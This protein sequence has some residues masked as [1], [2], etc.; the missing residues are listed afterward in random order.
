MRA[1]APRRTSA[2]RSTAIPAAHRPSTRTSA[3]ACCP[4]DPALSSAAMSARDPIQHLPTHDVENVPLALEDYDMFASD[5]G[6]REAAIREGG[7]WLADRCAPLGARL[8]SAEV[9]A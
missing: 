8:G 4:L 5:P 1:P 9:L 6:L 2:C 7:A 3:S